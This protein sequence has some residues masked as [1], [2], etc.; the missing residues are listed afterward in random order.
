VVKCGGDGDCP[1]SDMWC[2]GSFGS[3]SCQVDQCGGTPPSGPYVC[4]EK[5]DCGPGRI[6]CL[7]S[8]V[9]GPSA[10]CLN[11]GLCNSDAGGVRAEACNPATTPSEC[12][13]GTCQA[14]PNGPAGWYVCM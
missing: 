10:I 3:L 14:A 4:D 9:G 2:C 6:C 13:T 7:Q 11:A 5:A 8:T 1:D 12:S